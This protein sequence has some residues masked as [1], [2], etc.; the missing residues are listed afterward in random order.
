MRAAGRPVLQ[1]SLVKHG[2]LECHNGQR[3]ADWLLRFIDGM[4]DEGVVYGAVP[5]GFTGPLN[6]PTRLRRSAVN[7]NWPVGIGWIAR[8]P[9]SAPLLQR[10]NP[11]PCLQPKLLAPIQDKHSAIRQ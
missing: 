2:G 3:R 7:A 10:T 5:R 11:Q 4:L 6:L 9:V 1:I 8:S